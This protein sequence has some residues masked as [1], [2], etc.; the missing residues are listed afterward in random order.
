MAAARASSAGSS[1]P[2]LTSARRVWLTWAVRMKSRRGSKRRAAI[3]RPL[4][5]CAFASRRA[6]VGLR[7][8]QRQA[9]EAVRGR[10][11]AVARRHRLSD[12]RGT[13]RGVAWVAHAFRFPPVILAMNLIGVGTRIEDGGWKIEAHAQ[14]WLSILHPRSSTLA[15]SPRRFIGRVAGLALVSE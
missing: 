12:R 5:A 4:F 1:A 3:R 7:R 2:R 9:L 14:W 11:G 15:P 13:L 8:G 6:A 10:M